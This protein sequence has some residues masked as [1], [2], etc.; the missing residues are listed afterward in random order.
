MASVEAQQ[1]WRHKNK[2]VKRQLNIMARKNIHEYLEEIVDTHDLKGKGEAVA[3]A[4]YVTKALIQ[5]G[6]FNEEADHLHNIFT[7]SYRRDRD[8]YAP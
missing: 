7:E 6:D 1:K 5:Q 3:F 4:V 8:I 2:F